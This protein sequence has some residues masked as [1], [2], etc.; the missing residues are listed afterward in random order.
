MTLI[1]HLIEFRARLIKCLL[2]IGGGMI[3]SFAWAEPWLFR[4]ALAPLKGRD[5]I[6]LGLGEAFSIHLT[7]AFQIGCFIAAPVI[8]CQVWA[9]VSPGLYPNERRAAMRLAIVS[10]LLF[11]AG[12]GFGYF[13][14]LPIIVEFFLSFEV[15]GL[16]YGGAI[17]PYLSLTIGILLSAGIVFQLPLLMLGLLKS[18]LVTRETL[19]RQ[20]RRWILGIVVVSAALTPTGDAATLALFSIPIWLLFEMTLLLA[21]MTKSRS[22]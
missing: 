2:A 4:V 5:L 14:I 7:L 13:I 9:F 8:A 12:L 16:Q 21:H 22:S 15:E 20:R 18:G 11:A 19:A 6:Y 3:L 1:E 17:G 10:F